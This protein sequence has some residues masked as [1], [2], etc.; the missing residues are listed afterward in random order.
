MRGR[1]RFNL[2]EKSLGMRVIIPSKNDNLF[3]YIIYD[4]NSL[5]ADLGGYLGLLVGQSIFDMYQLMAG[6]MNWNK[7]TKLFMTRRKRT[8]KA[9]EKAIKT[10]S[11][12]NHTPKKSDIRIEG[13][14]FKTIANDKESSGHSRRF[15]DDLLEDI[16]A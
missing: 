11:M 4:W 1:N 8:I 13:L 7:A 5:L 15:V 2:K 6:W 16:P 12:S 14:G 10:A 9:R 3:Q